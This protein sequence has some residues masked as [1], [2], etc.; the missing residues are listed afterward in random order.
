M[1]QRLRLNGN[2]RERI[3]ADLGCPALGE[4]IFLFPKNRKCAFVRPSRTRK[5]AL[6]IVTNVG[7]GMRWTRSVD[8]DEAHRRGR[9]RRVVPIPRRWDQVC[10]DPADDGGYQAR[11]PG[12]ARISRNTIAQGMPVV[13][14][15]PV[16]ATRVLSCCTRGYGCIGHPAFPAPS[17][18]DEG[19]LLEEL[20]RFAPRERDP[21]V[22]ESSSL[23]IVPPEKID[24][25]SGTI[26]MTSAIAIAI[27]LAPDHGGAAPTTATGRELIRWWAIGTD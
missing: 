17:L 3:Q 16:V 13:C 1:P 20:G 7:R 9:Q 27:R 21:L 10:G 26:R 25:E 8:P 12:R 15:V 6:R 19:G 22:H 23:H 4:K 2:F 18:R 5:R 24:D 14:G 11:T